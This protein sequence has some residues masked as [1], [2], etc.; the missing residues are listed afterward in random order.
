MI[1]RGNSELAGA[2][3]SQTLLSRSYSY[4]NGSHRLLLSP[5]KEVIEGCH[6]IGDW[7]TEPSQWDL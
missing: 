1:F 7:S 5:K 3:Q 4:T 2:L 6:S